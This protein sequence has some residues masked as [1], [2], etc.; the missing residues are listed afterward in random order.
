MNNFYRIKNGRVI[1]PA[2]GVDRVEDVYV[3]NS[4]IVETPEC[5]ISENI[6]EINASGCL[7]LPGL[8][9]FHTHLN[10]Y[11]S[12]FGIHPD[13]M[14]FPNGITAAVDAGSSGSANFEG[15][16]RD[17]ICSSSTTI[18]SFINVSPLGIAT[19]RHMEDLNPEFYDV[20]RLE[21]IFERYRH[22]LLGLKVRI[23]KQNS[24]DLGLL[25]LKR[26]TELARYFGTGMCVHVVHPESPYDEILSHFEPGDILCHCFQSKGQYSI[27]NEKGKVCEA[28]KQ[29]RER[30]VIFD[31]ASGRANHDLGVIK[32][33][34]DDGFMPDI[35]STDVTISSIYT[36][37][38][39][40]LLYVMSYYLALGMPL[41]EVIRAVTA[42]P[43]ERMGM[44]G[45]IGTLAPGALADVTIFRLQEKPVVFSDQFENSFA[46]SRLFLPQMTIKAGKTVFM[47]IDFAF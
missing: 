18:K 4:K 9:D 47:Q 46:G 21:Y 6:E 39:F 5:K 44:E 28:A 36:K 26:T 33:A 1:D 7:V 34:L 3:R 38:P 19:D 24:G 25:P 32:K 42:A 29:A 17:V 22:E 35:I 31:G 16:Y 43:A 11:H 15:F 13:S 41:A 45:Q 23:G 37:S 8:I 10:R 12:D 30:G 40:S 2:R 20:S 14:T 27:L